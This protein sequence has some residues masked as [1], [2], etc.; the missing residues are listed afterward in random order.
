MRV[1]TYL[2]RYVSRNGCM[3]LNN[4][5]KLEKQMR[6]VIDQKFTRKCTNL[7]LSSESTTTCLFF[8]GGDSRAWRSAATLSLVTLVT[9]A[10]PEWVISG[11][12][13]AAV[14]TGES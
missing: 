7:F 3:Q 14:T 10:V 5:Q 6:N 2:L 12:G 1:N 13:D 9:L 8:W 11:S 4:A